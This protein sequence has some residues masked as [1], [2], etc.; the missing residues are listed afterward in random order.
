MEELRVATLQYM[1]VPGPMEREARKLRVLQSE[2]RGDVEETA[3]LMMQG[4]A[5]TNLA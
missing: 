5:S 4:H 1:N 3:N 2:L